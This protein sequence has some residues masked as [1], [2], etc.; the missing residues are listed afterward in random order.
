LEVETHIVND[1]YS[2]FFRSPIGISFQDAY[3]IMVGMP[4]LERIYSFDKTIMV[5]VNN[6]I[7][8]YKFADNWYKKCQ[9][10][11]QKNEYNQQVKNLINS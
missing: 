7:D 5:D 1:R 11:I 8:L 3:N 9:E 6:K 4:G 2:I 10:V